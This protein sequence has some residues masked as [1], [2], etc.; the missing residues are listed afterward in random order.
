M[1]QQNA[2][3]AACPRAGL[4]MRATSHRPVHHTLTRART[5]AGASPSTCVHVPLRRA[6]PW[7]A[8][9]GADLFASMSVCHAWYQAAV[10]NYQ[11]R[12]K[13]V[14]SVAGEL[15]HMVSLASPG[16]TILLDAGQHSVHSTVTIDVPLRLMATHPGDAVAIVAHSCVAIRSR[17]NVSCDGLEMRRLRAAGAHPNSVIHAEAGTLELSNCVVLGA[18][19]GEEEYGASWKKSAFSMAELA[20][21]TASTLCNS[22]QQLLS[23]AAGAVGVPPPMPCRQGLHAHEPPQTGV[24]VGPAARAE[25]IDCRIS[26]HRGPA[27]KVCR[28]QL[29]A[30]K[31]VISHSACGANVVVNGGRIELVDNDVHSARGD[32]IASWNN[33]GLTIEGNRIHSNAGSGIALNSDST[34]T[35]ITANHIFGNSVAAVRNSASCAHASLVG[36]TIEEAEGAV[37]VSQEPCARACAAIGDAPNPMRLQRSVTLGAM[38]FD[39]VCAFDSAREP[40]PVALRASRSAVDRLWGGGSAFDS[41]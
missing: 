12:W 16:D 18:E 22:P 34:D 32:G 38:H 30:R 4:L 35:T 25:L 26:H 33:P 29:I 21:A 23:S 9:W 19:A 3:V 15:S 41:D 28:G 14:A 13:Q 5:A 7:L 6:V 20:S 31:S 24:S 40:P 36:N 10:A 8:M 1:N 27:V 11:R 17:T 39:D 2:L 37:S